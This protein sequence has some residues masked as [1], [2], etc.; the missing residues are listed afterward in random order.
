MHRPLNVVAPTDLAVAST[1]LKKER[2]SL[3]GPMT[4]R[5]ILQPTMAA[6]YA[7]RD[8]VK[9]AKN[10]RPAYFWTIFAER[11]E[12]TRLLNEAWHAAFRV[13]LL[14]C[15][16][17]IVYQVMAF[18]RIYPLEVV[19]VVLVLAF[20]PYVLLRGRFNRIARRWIQV[21]KTAITR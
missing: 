2:R 21:E 4:F 19:V 11:S 7:L 9:D 10:G 12:W 16:M 13:T 20:A 8:G 5:L 14:G 6:L 3:S 18:G 15:I 1:W 17:D